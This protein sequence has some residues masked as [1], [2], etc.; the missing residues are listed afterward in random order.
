[1]TRL[2]E[3]VE[4]HAEAAQVTCGL[5]HALVWHDMRCGCEGW[6]YQVAQP[7]EDDD[8]LTLSVT[9]WSPSLAEVVAQLS[10]YPYC[11][12]PD[13]PWRESRFPRSAGT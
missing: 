13:L 5:W 10:R 11:L 6:R 2:A 3:V 4:S 7:G 12:S 8:D 9:G 1:M